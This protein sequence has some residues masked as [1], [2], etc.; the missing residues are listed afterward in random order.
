MRRSGSTGKASLETII[1]ADG[2]ANGLD[3]TGGLAVGGA[4]GKAI[5]LALQANNNKKL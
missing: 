3:T 1:G 2:A 5:L 4:S